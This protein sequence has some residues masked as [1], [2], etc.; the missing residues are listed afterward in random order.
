MINNASDTVGERLWR[1]IDKL[2]QRPRETFIIDGRDLCLSAHPGD[3]VISE[4]CG[5]L[6]KRAQRL[7]IQ[8]SGV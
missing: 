7:S 2:D 3:P 5:L 4:L 6:E 1:V 8:S